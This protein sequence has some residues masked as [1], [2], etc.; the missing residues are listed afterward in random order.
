[1]ANL[2]INGADIKNDDRTLFGEFLNQ[3]TR[4]L[5]I[6][7]QVISLIKI[8]GE[9]LDES[10]ESQLA[11][12][13]LGQIKNIDITTS[14]QLDLAF[15]ALNT[16]KRY[17]RKLVVLSRNTGGLY[18]KNG[19]RITAEKSFLDLVEGL[20]NLT[21]LLVSAQSVLRGKFKGVHTNDSSLR[22]AQVRLVS[23]IEELL[24]AKK[25]NDAVMLSDILI[26]ELP[27]A[28]SEMADYGIPV[29]Q[30]LKST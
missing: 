14:N 1:M 30:R 2:R 3:L 13:S 18:Q 26:N 6:R 25:A 28:L 27:S 11:M 10:Y 5:A 17:I 22:I 16:A 19:D 24:P 21:N 15:E 4:D 9:V 7:S 12:Q 23:A 8:D 29:L 20:D